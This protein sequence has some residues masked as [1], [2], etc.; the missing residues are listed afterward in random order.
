MTSPGTYSFPLEVLT[1]YTART[2]PIALPLSIAYDD[3]YRGGGESVASSF[4]APPRQAPRLLGAFVP[5]IYPIFMSP[6][7]FVTPL[8]VRLQEAQGT[9][10]SLWANVSGAVQWT[11]RSLSGLTRLRFTAPSVAEIVEARVADTVEIF[12]RI[13]NGEY[14]C[15]LSIEND[16]SGCLC[17]CAFGGEC[18]CGSDCPWCH[19]DEDNDNSQPSD[20]PTP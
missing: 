18:T 16:H 20:E 7:I 11:Y 12:L 13:D 1:E 2:Y 19:H 15:Q 8:S 14:G 17:G 5:H 6:S 10:I 3:G 9:L 4:A